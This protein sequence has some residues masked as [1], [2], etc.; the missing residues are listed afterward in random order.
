MSLDRTIFADDQMYR[1]NSDHYFSCGKS[2]A[3]VLA[4]AARLTNVTPETILDYGAG[5]GR[6]TRWLKMIFP[7]ARIYACDVRADDMEFLRATFGA[8]TWVVSPDVDTL[9]IPHCADLVWAGSVVT[10]LSR[11]DAAV[12]IA[13]LLSACNPGG[14][15]AFSFHGSSVLSRGHAGYIHKAAWARIKLGYYLTGYGYADYK[16]QKSYGISVCSPAWIVQL[17]RS[18]SDVQ[19]KLL[20][21]RLWDD[22]HDVVVLAKSAF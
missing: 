3:D 9:D 10:H 22:H 7:A 6:V 4:A 17:A 11:R 19:I 8:E 2:A 1:D 20:G 13:K 18:M 21:E 5:A 14:L 16:G 15:V 12:L